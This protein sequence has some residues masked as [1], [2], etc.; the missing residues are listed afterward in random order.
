MMRSVAAFAMFVLMGVTS[1]AQD[2]TDVIEQ[3]ANSIVFLD[4]QVLDSSNAI[5][6]RSHGTGFVVTAVEGGA[7]VTYVVTNRHV[8]APAK[9]AGQKVEVYGKL[10]NSEGLGGRLFLVTADDD[11]DLAI[12]KF[13]N[14]PRDAAGVKF[15]E[16]GMS[17]GERVLVIGFPD[18]NDNVGISAV[19]TA[20]LVQNLAEYEGRAVTQLDIVIRPGNSG[21]PIFNADGEVVGVVFSRQIMDRSGDWTDNIGFAFPV[22]NVIGLLSKVGIVIEQ[23]SEVSEPGPSEAPDNGW[24]WAGYLDRS[25][26]TR[27]ATGPF[28]SV[29]QR[30]E[31]ISRQYPIRVGDLVKPIHDLKQVI[32]GY[33][34]QGERNVLAPPPSLVSIIDPERDYTGRVWMPENVLLVM[35]VQVWSAAQDSD[36]VVWL[37]VIPQGGEITRPIENA[38][39]LRISVLNEGQA[40]ALNLTDKFTDTTAATNFSEQP[41]YVDV[42]LTGST[43]R[44]TAYVE[45]EDS[46]GE[47]SFPLLFTPAFAG[48]TVDVYFDG[49]FVFETSLTSEQVEGAC[50]KRTPTGLKDLFAQ[51][52]ECRAFAL[53]LE[54]KNDAANQE[55]LVVALCGWLNANLALYQ[56]VG[57]VSPYG[58]DMDLLQRL[59][60]VSEPDMSRCAAS[61]RTFV[62]LV[63][64]E[65]A[66]LGGTV[67]S[68]VAAGMIDEAIAVNDEALDAFVGAGF[69]AGQFGLS[70]QVLLDNSRYLQTLKL[71]Q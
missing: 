71:A 62:G 34:D 26:H 57:P 55:R 42:A 22:R 5:V 43:E 27:W 40:S 69:K 31:A 7:R 18:L 20:G 53:E 2:W 38:V 15:D 3:T 36:P 52:H 46:D 70:E 1:F 13:A 33:Q 8:A 65:V 4:V 17:N 11:A 64:G 44:R 30:S 21:G 19:P 48:E 61:S 59:Q 50:G 54:K 37:R 58:A 47:A 39:Q 45:W 68:L 49:P 29:V 25:N 51:Y 41:I 66:R 6:S 63:V 9:G 24:V 56:R 32:V 12:M 28:V 14:G 23:H 16:T 60:Q 35:D 10:G 67:P